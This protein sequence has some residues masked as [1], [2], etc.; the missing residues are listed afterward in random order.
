MTR[1]RGPQLGE[2][3][4]LFPA[5]FSLHEPLFLGDSPA[6][7]ARSPRASGPGD[8]EG[9]WGLLASFRD[10]D[11][12][13]QESLVTFPRPHTPAG[14]AAKAEL[15]CEAKGLSSGCAQPLPS[16]AQAQHRPDRPGPQS[17][18]PGR[19]PQRAGRDKHPPKRSSAPTDTAPRP[20]AREKGHPVTPSSS[21]VTGK[22]PSPEPQSGTRRWWAQ[23]RARP[24]AV[25]GA[26]GGIHKVSGWGR[27]WEG[28][29]EAYLSRVCRGSWALTGG[30]CGGPGRRGHGGEKHTAWGVP[31]SGARVRAGTV[32]PQAPS[33]QQLCL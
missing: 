6:K 15:G 33:E 10:G 17:C 16:A 3:R 31:P 12:E 1:S 22:P 2:Q 30:G 20:K 24:R 21:P 13:A 32:T 4:H 28:S 5:R 18:W 8:M 11:A 7:G 25:Q 9:T 26:E 27:G 19:I 23:T 29:Q 14:H